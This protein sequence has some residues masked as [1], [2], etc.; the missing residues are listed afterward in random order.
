MADNVFW[1]VECQPKDAKKNVENY[2]KRI[3]NSHPESCSKHFEEMRT[4]QHEIKYKHLY[5]RRK[6]S[7][8][9]IWESMEEMTNAGLLK[10]K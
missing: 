2:I 8:K 10:E 4:M 1:H 9:Q 7:L 6:M 5:E 3:S